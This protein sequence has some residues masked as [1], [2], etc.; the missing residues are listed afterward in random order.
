MRKI[1]SHKGNKEAGRRKVP[2]EEANNLS[3]STKNTG[4]INSRRMR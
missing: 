4:I 1:L 2:I 3:S